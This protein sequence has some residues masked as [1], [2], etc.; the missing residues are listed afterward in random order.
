MNDKIPDEGGYVPSPAQVRTLE[1]AR[2]RLAERFEVSEMRSHVRWQH[3]EDESVGIPALGT[4]VWFSVNVGPLVVFVK[5]PN[6]FQKPVDGELAASL[7]SSAPLSA[8]SPFALVEDDETKQLLARLGFGAIDRQATWNV[9]HGTDAIAD[10]IVR[11]ID[12]LAA[13]PLRFVRP[14]DLLPGTNWSIAENGVLWA[15]SLKNL[16]EDPSRRDEDRLLLQVNGGPMR[17]VIDART[18]VGA[19]A[20]RLAN[21]FKDIE[22]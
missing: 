5:T 22:S 7:Q 20:W 10:A 6:V 11:T 16:G 8:A 12:A 21:G 3:W 14:D 19:R 13:A 4:D 17:L 2:D 15:T 18:L 1:L 9:E